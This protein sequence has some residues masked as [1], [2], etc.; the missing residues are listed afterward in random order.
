[1]AN[2]SDHSDG[3][4]LPQVMRGVF[5]HDKQTYS[6]NT[7]T[8]NTT[9]NPAITHALTHGLSNNH[10]ATAANLNQYLP[11]L[12]QLNGVKGSEVGMGRGVGGGLVGASMFMSGRPQGTGRGH[13]PLGTLHQSLPRHHTLSMPCTS[14]TTTNI[15]HAT[16]NANEEDAS[17]KSFSRDFG[18]GC[19]HQEDLPHTAWNN[20]HGHHY[21]NS[22]TADF[23]NSYLAKVN[24]INA[25]GG[26][27][28]NSP[29]PH[30]D[31]NKLIT[32]PNSY[33]TQLSATPMPP[34]VVAMLKGNSNAAH[35]HSPWNHTYM[36]LGTESSDPV[37]EEIE[38]EKYLNCG[39]Q[40]VQ[41]VGSLTGCEEMQVSDLSDDYVK[42]RAPSD[43]SHQSSH[44]YGDARLLIPYHSHQ[45]AH[46]RSH[47]EQQYALSEERLR[48]FNAAQMSQDL[49]Q[50]QH[51]Q[52]QYNQE[53]LMTVAVLNGERVVCH[54]T[55]PSNPNQPQSLPVIPEASR[56]GVMVSQPQTNGYP[57][58]LVASHP[59]N[60]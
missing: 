33:T 55:S 35:S 30:I 52:Q 56:G 40:T 18:H 49:E 12:C 47:Q 42:G 27:D 19:S 24:S 45:M 21:S 7:N 6:P 9:E 23:K 57:A 15:H 4:W 38:R 11:N 44:S 46:P 41:G 31:G 13:L 22:L 54:L 34:A 25:A 10:Q 3:A 59:Q 5:T 58:H 53:N 51:V 43:M 37:Y 16:L 36:E 60:L 48:D 28:G 20:A 26:T 2:S 50:L 29:Y 14:T 39:G 17:F 1:G 8:S 32:V